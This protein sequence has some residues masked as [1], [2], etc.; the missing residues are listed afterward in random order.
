[1][2]GGIR[3]IVAF[4][5][6]LNHVSNGK[7]TISGRCGDILNC[8]LTLFA[9]LPIRRTLL[10]SLLT[11]LPISLI[12]SLF[13]KKTT[14]SRPAYHHFGGSISK[15]GK[16]AAVI[17]KR[18]SPWVLGCSRQDILGYCAV[19]YLFGSHSG[20]PWSRATIQLQPGAPPSH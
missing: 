18:L 9:S 20:N 10:N 11:F 15:E 3:E 6:D 4:P 12:S 17:Q 13:P 19:A 1:V 5:V 7:S 8:E 2:E 16:G 14:E